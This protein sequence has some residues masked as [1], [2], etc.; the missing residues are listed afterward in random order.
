MSVSSNI[1]K[2]S[3]MV[4][5]RWALLIMPVL[6]LFY[7]ENGLSMTRVLI[8]QSVFSVSLVVFEAP[9]GY[10]S[11]V[12]GRKSSLIVGSVAATV[13]WIVYVFAYGFWGFLVAELIMGMGM[14]FI[15]G[16][17]SAILYDTLADEGREGD[18]LKTQGRLSSIG[19]FSE[20]GGAIVGGLLATI[21]L[22]TPFYAQAALV[23]M[24]IP[25]ALSIVEPQRTSLQNA[26]G[27]LRGIVRIVKYSLHDHGEIKWLI[28]YS[29][30]VGA[31]TLTLVW[32][33]QPYFKLVGV[34]LVLFGA[35]WAA[36]QLSTGF[37]SLSAHRVEKLIGRQTT[38][39]GLIVLAGTGYAMLALFEAPWAIAFIFLMYFV[40]GINSPVLKDYVNRLI[41]SDIR[42]TVLSVNSLVG[43]LVFVMVGPLI[44]WISDTYSL[45]VAFATAG[46]FF[47]SSGVVALLFLHRYK[48]LC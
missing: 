34:P 42:A 38:L 22:R 19:N 35:L 47:F 21:S 18:Y 23:A 30:L 33:I 13:G 4:A 7:Q 40:R 8:L 29:S 39:I 44:G 2:L 31:S 36:L 11:D 10:F 37:F 45:S 25:L 16:T 6:I 3:V 14:S 17:D 48:A 1:W 46:G 15:S 5:L 32:F 12:V 9:S 24:T 43:R 28:V 41:D 27:S 26:E 20:A